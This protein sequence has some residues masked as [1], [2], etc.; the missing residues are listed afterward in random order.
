MACVFDGKLINAEPKTGQ[1]ASFQ[2]YIDGVI[3]TTQSNAAE[4]A[5]AALGRATVEERK[6]AKALCGESL[7]AE[8][9]VAYQNAFCKL[10]DAIAAYVKAMGVS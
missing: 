3:D 7:E 10:Q 9:H 6:A 5:L 4:T 8:S 1:P 2:V